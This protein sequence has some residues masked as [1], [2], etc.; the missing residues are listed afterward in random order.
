M[1]IQVIMPSVTMNTPLTHVF[2]PFALVAVHG[3]AWS[4]LAGSNP[5]DAAFAPRFEVSGSVAAAIAQPDNKVY[6]DDGISHNALV[7]LQPE[8]QRDA[9]F[10]P[11]FESTGTEVRSFLTTKSGQ[12]MITGTFT[13]ADG[14]PRQ[15]VVK[16]TPSPLP[17]RL[18]IRRLTDPHVQLTW[19]NYASNWL[20]Q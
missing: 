18:K 16:Y 7:R 6:G 10:A 15:S 14:M 20:R 9:T 8:G 1:V 11:S 2:R 4:L 13:S 17:P 12:L 3:M 5:P 19:P